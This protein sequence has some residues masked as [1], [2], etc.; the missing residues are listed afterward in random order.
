MGD[1]R[2]LVSTF[3]DTVLP[4]V[5]KDEKRKGERVI[6]ANTGTLRFDLVRPFLPPH[7]I[8]HS[9][10]VHSSRPVSRVTYLKEPGERGWRF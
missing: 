3:G 2:H 1:P 10:A 9:V 5:L 6:I 7:L 4:A 8:L